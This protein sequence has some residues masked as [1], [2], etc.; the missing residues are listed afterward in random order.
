MT[1]IKIMSV[2]VV[3]ICSKCRR[4]GDE[5]MKDKNGKVYTDEFMRKFYGSNMSNKNYDEFLKFIE[6]KAGNKLIDSEIVT[7]KMGEEK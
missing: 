2:K 4:E 6:D 3:G 5:I 7:R 1:G